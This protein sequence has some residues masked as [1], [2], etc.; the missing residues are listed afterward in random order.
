[1]NNQPGCLAHYFENQVYAGS[2][3][4]IWPT[5]GLLILPDCPTDIPTHLSTVTDRVTSQSF[6]NVK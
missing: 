2:D 5:L 6:T 3:I 4:M 1:M